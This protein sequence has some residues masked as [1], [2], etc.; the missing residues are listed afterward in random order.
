MATA[1][2]GTAKRSAPAKKKSTAKARGTARKGGSAKAKGTAKGKG[3][4]AARRL[5]MIADFVR[6]T[7]LPKATVSQIVDVT[8]I[9]AGRWLVEVAG[10]HDKAVVALL[11]SVPGVKASTF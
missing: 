3:R 2:K 10:I 8:L 1:K 9:E 6:R 7:N 11:Q 5:E 4:F